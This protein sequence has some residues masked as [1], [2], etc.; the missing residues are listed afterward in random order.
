MA[1]QAQGIAG[2]KASR[3][4]ASNACSRMSQSVPLQ[5]R[6]V[7]DESHG[8]AGMPVVWSGDIASVF[9]S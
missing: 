1:F 7:D 6:E 4:R 2:G 3:Q 5:D 8:A 9:S